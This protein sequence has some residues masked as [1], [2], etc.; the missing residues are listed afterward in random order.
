MP[1][2]FI[3]KAPVQAIQILAVRSAIID[4]MAK[5]GLWIAAGAGRLADAVATSIEL[6]EQFSTTVVQS[7]IKPR[8]AEIVI[9]SLN[10]ENIDY[11]GISQ[12]GRRVATGQITIAVSNLKDVGVPCEDLKAALPPR[13]SQY[14]SILADGAYRPTPR[15]WEE[16]LN[17][18]RKKEPSLV[19]AIDGLTRRVAAA[20]VRPGRISGGLEVFERDAVASALQVFGGSAFR[21]KVLRKAGAP[22]RGSVAPF[23]LRLGEVS[24]REDP[25]IVNDQSVFPGLNV[26]RRDV[27]GSVFLTNG[28]DDLTI[29]NCNRQPLERT[30]GVDLIY[31]SHR[32]DSFVLV[33]YKRMTEGKRGAEYRPA[34]DPS[35]EE[36]IKRMLQTEEF[37]RKQPASKNSGTTDYRLSGRPFFVKLCEPKAKAALDAGMVSGMYVPLRLWRKLLSSPEV[38]GKKGGVVVTWDNCARRFNNGEF[39]NLLRNGWIGSAAGESKALAKIVEQVL[40]SGRMLVFAETSKARASQDLRRDHLGRFATDDDPT[41]AF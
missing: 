35:H 33:Q 10:G 31:Y 14:F 30:L 25:Q 32:F 23:L 27:I 15:V 11:V 40:S 29:L 7:E 2:V 13:L 3:A 38:V 6:H 24:V 19:E 5:S 22:E 41:A 9:V 16:I 39:T 4:R 21:K 36:E 17:I 37:L 12:V 28:T 34:S 1:P 8:Q 18:L 20:Q 26:A